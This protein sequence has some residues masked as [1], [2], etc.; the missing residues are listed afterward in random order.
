MP[1][2]T[3]DPQSF[4]IDGRRTWLVSAAIHYP[5]TPREL[6]R[7]RIRAAKQAGCNCIETYVFWNVHEPQP[8]RFKF[9]GDA[10]L[11][12]FIEIVGEEDLYCIVRPGPYVCSEWDFGGLP[13]WLMDIDDIALRQANPA[14]LQATARYLDAVLKQIADLQ[15]TRPGG[16]PIIMMQNENEWFCNNDEQIAGYHEQITR[17]MRESGCEVPL[18]NCN[19]LW[20][21]VPNTI[22]CWNGW[23]GIARDCRQLRIAQPDA[24]RFVTELWPG[25][26]DAWGKPHEKQKSG[27]DV[28]RALAEVSGTG[29][30]FN[31][32]M[33]HGGTNFGFWG[34][35]TV[36]SPDT[37]M[38]TSYDYDAPLFEAGGRGDKY[39]Q[40]KRICM[41]LS[42]FG[43]VMAN[44]S[45]DEQPTVATGGHD[46]SIWQQS[47]AMGRVVFLTRQ[48]PYK[49]RQVKLLTPNGL[50]L[51]IAMG[52]DSA[53]W[54]LLDASLGGVATLDATN[55]RPWAFVD[56][57]MLVLYGPAGTDAVVSIDHAVLSTTVPTGSKP[58]VEQHQNLTVVILNEQQVDA[59][60]PSDDD[61][62][63]VG[64][65]GF[66]DEGEPVR[67]K[68]GSYTIIES[69]GTTSSKRFGPAPRVATP[70]LGSWTQVAQSDY[71]DGTAPRFAA[72]D[73]PRALESCGA[74]YGYGWYRVSIDAPAAKKHRLFAPMS[75]DRLH[76]YHNGKYREIIGVGAGAT[77]APID[78]NLAKGNNELVFLADNLGRYNYGRL[79]G[80][81]KGLHG[82]LYDAKLV[83][84]TKPTKTTEP[85]ANPFEL[86]GY[87]QGDRQGDRSLRNRY[88]F[89]IN[90]R[91]KTPLIIETFGNRPHSVVFVNGEAI[92]IDPGMGL[93]HRILLEQGEQLKQGKNEITFAL[94]DPEPSAFN[95]AKHITVYEGQTTLSEKAK[96]AY[97]RWQMPQVEQFDD[98]PA[99]PEAVPTWHRC[100]FKVSQTDTPLW[101]EIAGMSKGQIYLNGYNVGR[102]FVA[103]STGKKV[104]PQ[105]RYY[106]PEPWLNTDEPN[107]L[108]LFDEHGQ[109]P[110]K[111]KLVYD[112]MGPFN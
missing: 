48:A 22:D 86:T 38:I 112:K 94:L 92:D 12:R 101:V 26:F 2:I 55:L 21:H 5:R 62:L 58:T 80:E 85:A 65:D 59:A 13:A 89:T 95:I 30:M 87:A 63:F 107:E 54:V 24:P 43:S 106:L 74:D 7:S 4:I 79:L 67:G 49:A 81:R 103:T 27:E 32:Y 8:G 97:A 52:K 35:R 100:E 75:G 111:C 16:G 10:D 90:H 9:D 71:A 69:D 72:I 46:V 15:I 50:T 39:A 34:G 33:F 64:I 61:Q 73:G 14:F 45:P 51:D 78:L 53:A 20:Q 60:Y 102:Y 17:Y 96:W 29:A 88:T 82:H 108:I 47:G 98:P 57:Q 23:N 19:N 70:K 91:R 18:I 25:W 36:G 99:K 77:D 41:F 68:A 84:L 37:H 42:Q 31:L 83:K 109:A 11:R 104:P 56:Q 6:W 3:Y 93:T 40:T 28:L 66:D 76:L 44:L 1:T 105:S 110:T